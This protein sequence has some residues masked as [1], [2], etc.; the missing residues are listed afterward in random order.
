VLINYGNIR[1]GFGQA[2]RNGPANVYGSSGYNGGFP[3]K[4]KQTIKGF[5]DFELGL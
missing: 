5:H 3:A 2:Q 1:T 4:R